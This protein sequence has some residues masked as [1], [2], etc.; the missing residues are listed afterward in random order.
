MMTTTYKVRDLPSA[1]CA[2]DYWVNGKSVFITATMLRDA[3]TMAYAQR[4]S[5]WRNVVDLD[6]T[7]TVIILTIGTQNDCIDYA[8]ETLFKRDV[9]P[10][11]NAKGHDQATRARRIACNNGE[12]YE[13]QL[14]ACRA[15]GLNQGAVSRQLRGELRSV[16]GYVFCYEDKLK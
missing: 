2:V 6:A 8:N 5:E 16:K 15:L 10:H 7:V 1:W 11:C 9:K 13:S 12:V 4:N 14:A 3:F